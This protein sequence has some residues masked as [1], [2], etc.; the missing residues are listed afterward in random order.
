MI[1]R[2]IS[3]ASAS[4]MRAHFGCIFK[5][6]H[7]RLRNETLVCVLILKKKLQTKVRKRK[8]RLFV[9]A[10]RGVSSVGLFLFV[11]CVMRHLPFPFPVLHVAC[12][13]L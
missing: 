4:T 8:R 9:T 13:M 1:S 12:C 11:I 3:L 6:S 5:A 10:P 7:C 2:E